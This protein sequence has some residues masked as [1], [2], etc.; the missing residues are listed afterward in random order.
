MTGPHDAPLFCGRS[1]ADLRQE[2]LADI[3][4]RAAN[5]DSKSRE[6]IPETMFLVGVLGKHHLGLPDLHFDRVFSRDVAVD[7]ERVLEIHIPMV[8]DSR[9]LQLSPSEPAIDEGLAELLSYDF[10]DGDLCLTLPLRNDRPGD[11]DIVTDELLE[12]AQRRYRAVEAELES[13]RRDA[14]K[15][16]IEQYRRNTDPRPQETLF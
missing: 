13:L 1:V 4:E 12:I 16:A 5:L 3:R 2:V 7:G 10:V 15:T 6:H 14:H 11:V 8:G 9:N